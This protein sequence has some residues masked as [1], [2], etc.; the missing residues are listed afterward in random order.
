MVD[1]DRDNVPLEALR[2]IQLVE[3]LDGPLTVEKAQRRG[4]P[5]P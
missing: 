4:G 2:A 5:T 1:I 3:G